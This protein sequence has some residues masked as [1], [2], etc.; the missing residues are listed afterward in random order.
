[1]SGTDIQQLHM[2]V[3]FTQIKSMLLQPLK[4]SIF[5]FKLGNEGQIKEKS[6]GSDHL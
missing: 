5:P 1:M 2:A 4:Y 3:G 6:P